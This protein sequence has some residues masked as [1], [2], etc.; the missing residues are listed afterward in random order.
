[1]K[2]YLFPILILLFL[3][4]ACNKATPTLASTE[5]PTATLPPTPTSEP[6]ALRVN[7][8]G[9]LLTD[10]QA[11]LA[12]LVQAETELNQPTTPEE[13]KNRVVQNY[14][15]Q[16][17]LAQAAVQSGFS[18]D[19]AALQARIDKLITEVGDA[20]KLAA[21][22]ATYGYT[23]ASFRE[24]LRREILAAWQRDQIINAVP[25][26]AEQIHALQ[27]LT[28][29]EAN[30]NDAYQKLQDGMKFADL[31]LLYD[32]VSGGDIGW[33][34]AGT[35][36]QPAVDAAAFALQ[37]G[38]YSAVIQSDLGY[39]IIYVIDRDP[40]HILSTDGRRILQEAALTKWLEDSRAVSTI[41]ILV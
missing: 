3:L 35:L 6:M 4:A 1:M 27:I 8:E 13:Q 31:A 40:Q 19:D 21:W 38:E 34:A 12:R 30:A 22:Q 17:L 23:D 7:G 36:T 24:A 2:R 25:T 20:D 16:L 41:E 39:H 29:D 5:T 14:V 37:P 10:Y 32:R 33:F 26:T 18:V 15:D 9:I 28:Q 11:E